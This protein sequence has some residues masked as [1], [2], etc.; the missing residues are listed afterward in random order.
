MNVQ[1]DRI[2]E[3]RRL[4]SSG[5]FVMPNPWDMGSARALERLGF[6][7]LATTSAGLAWTLGRADTEVTRDETLDHLR[8]VAGAVTVPVNADFEGGYAVAPRDVCE[9]EDGRGHGDRRALD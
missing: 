4:H 3:F 5:C 9:R 8:L 7:A 1:N 6:K 2:V